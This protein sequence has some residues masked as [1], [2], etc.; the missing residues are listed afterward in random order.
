MTLTRKQPRG[1]IKR[2]VFARL[3][4]YKKT[5]KDPGKDVAHVARGIADKC[6]VA[7]YGYSF[8]SIRM[9]SSLERYLSEH[10]RRFLPPIVRPFRPTY[11]F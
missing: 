11:D 2:F 7:I 10:S 9:P 6:R 3:P 4:K 1:C 8:G 5:R